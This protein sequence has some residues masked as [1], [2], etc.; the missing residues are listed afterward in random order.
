MFINLNY[1]KMQNL[2]NILNLLELEFFFN[3]KFF[4]LTDILNTEKN[5]SINNNKSKLIRKTIFKQYFKYNFLNLKALKFP[6]SI[7]STD[8]SFTDFF[9]S[10]FVKDN[11]IKFILLKY[12]NQIFHN[13]FNLNKNF[14]DS[15]SN[16]KKFFFLLNNYINNIMFHFFILFSIKK[17]I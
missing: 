1:N 14:F 8:Q 6:I 13:S 12:N 15:I 11:T 9:S 10:F 16:F 2:F 7:T 4:I 17:Y 3:Y 5:L